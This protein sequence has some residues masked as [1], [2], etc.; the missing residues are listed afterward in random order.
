MRFNELPGLT[1]TVDQVL[2]MPTMVDEIGEPHSFAYYLSIHN[3]SE[4]VVTIL[5]RKW[6]VQDEEGMTQVVEG[7][8]VVGHTPKLKPGQSFSY[9]SYHLI[10]EAST[11]TGTFFGE[12]SEGTPIYV[13]VPEFRMD[14]QE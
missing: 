5:G 4:E 14:V 2:Q 7:N 10:R 9:N 1:V 12:T 3:H 6:I 8:G 11:A 13:R